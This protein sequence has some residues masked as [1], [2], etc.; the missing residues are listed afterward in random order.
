MNKLIYS[1]LLLFLATSSASAAT[2]DSAL[3][4]SRLAGMIKDRLTFHAYGQAGY[5][6]EK[7]NGVETNTFDLKRVVVF[8]QAKVTEQWSFMFMYNFGNN[9]IQEFY[10]DFAPING[11]TIRVGQFK[12]PLSIENPLAPTDLELVNLNAQSVAYL[13]GIFSDPLYGNNAGRDIGVMLHGDLFDKMFHYEVAVM[14]G[15]GI[16]QRDSNNTKD[17]VAKIGLRPTSWLHI[18]AS[19]QKGHGHA[20]GVSTF[21]PEIQ[22][23]DNYRRDRLTAG[24]EVCQMPLFNLRAEYLAGRDRN[25]KSQGAYATACVPLLVRKTDLHNT[26]D[27]I[28]SADYFN[29]N[30]SADMWQTNF[31][32]GLQYWYYKFCRVQA[33]YVRCAPNNAPDYNSLQMQVQV[34]F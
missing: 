12:T 18:S 10:T 17:I 31:I 15:Q 9:T 8:T 25:V 16:N 22:E 3:I 7:N 6:Y 14:N 20:V 2:P 32:V 29:R 13:T 24:C 34:A 28:L 5:T 23:G 4:V 33:Q 27:L 26:L 1:L 30:K 19:G 11:L 21:N